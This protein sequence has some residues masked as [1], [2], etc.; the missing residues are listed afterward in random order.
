METFRVHRLGLWIFKT[1]MMKGVVCPRGSII[2]KWDDKL[3]N[4]VNCACIHPDDV[5][6]YIEQNK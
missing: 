4:Y 6:S 5:N 3:N 2:E 1:G